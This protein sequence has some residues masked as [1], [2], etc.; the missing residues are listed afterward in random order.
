VPFFGSY[1]QS[2]PVQLAREGIEKFKK[3]RF[4][5]VI[6]DTS[7]RHKQETDLFKE[8]HEIDSVVKSSCV[9]FVLDGSIG[10]AW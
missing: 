8:M 2:D 4:D 6:V 9:C 5:L 7:G 1:T 10:Q 3:E